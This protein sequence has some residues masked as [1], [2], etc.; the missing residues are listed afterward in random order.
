[1]ANPPIP[2]RLEINGLDDASFNQLYQSIS[3]FNPEAH[4]AEKKLDKLSDQAMGLEDKASNFRNSSLYK[5]A[6]AVE[7]ADPGHLITRSVGAVSKF[8]EN[9]AVIMK[10]LDA[11][12]QV[13]PFISILVLAFQAAIQLE[14][15]RRE[16]DK[17]VLL[18]KTDMM[19][20]MG[21]LLD[22]GSIKDAQKLD[23][24]GTT[25]EGR[26]QR[27]IKNA[28]QDIR[29]CSATCEKYLEKKFFVKLFDGSRWEGRLAAFS[30]VFSR[31]KDELSVALSIHTAQGVDNV[32]RTLVG[33]EANVKTG[34]ESAAM[35]ILF[36]QL[37]SP[38][39]RELQKWILDRGGPKTALIQLFKE[40]QDKMKDSKD[41]SVMSGS[42]TRTLMVSIREEMRENI[43]KSLAADRRQFDR[44][45][46]A[47]Q[48]KLEEMKNTVRRSTDRILIELASGPHDRIRDIDLYTVW[49]D[50]AWKGSVKARHFIVAVQDYFLHKYNREDQK[51]DDAVRG[52]AE[53][54]SGPS[55]PVLS[56]A[57]A[58]T[59]EPPPS[60]LVA[61]AIEARTAQREL[62]D[63]W[64]I[65]YI[66]L[67]RV[68]PILEA[69]DDDGSGWIS[70]LEANTFTSSRPVDY[71]VVKWLAFWAAG[72]RILCASYAQDIQNV[73]SRMIAIAVDVLPPN[74]AR[75]DKYMVSSSFD[76]VD[77]IVRAVLSDWNEDTDNDDA[78]MARFTDYIQSEEK[79]LT[80]GL[81]RFAWE[82][83]APNTLQL[84]AGTGR[85]ERSI[86][87][88]IFLVLKRHT[89]V[90]QLACKQPLDDREL[91]DAER[92]VDVL[93][94]AI[95]LRIFTLESNFRSQRLDPAS[96]FEVAYN[97]MFKMAYAYYNDSNGEIY[98]SEYPESYYNDDSEKEPDEKILKYGTSEA[99]VPDV[100]YRDFSLDD[101]APTHPFNGLW[102]GTYTYG[103]DTSIKDGIVSAHLQ[104]LNDDTQ[105]VFSGS[106]R[107][108]FGSFQISGSIT[109]APEGSSDK[110]GIT[111]RLEY[112]PV[113]GRE[114]LVWAYHGTVS[115]EESG[116]MT[117]MTGEW[118]VWVDD[119][120]KFEAAGTFQ[121]DRT[122]A[123]VAYH[124]PP[125]ADFEANAARARWKL[126]LNV[127]EEQVRR[128]RWSWSYFRQRREDR[129]IFV[130]A[131]V[132]TLSAASFTRY[133]RVWPSGDEENYWE[134]LNSLQCRLRP[135]DT[136][137]YNWLA[138]LR[139]E[140]ECFHPHT[141]C[142]SCGDQIVGVRYRC[143]DCI[144]P[145]NSG[146]GVDLDEKCK[147][148]HVSIPA[149]NIEHSPTAHALL[150]TLRV[151]YIRR[152][153]V[154]LRWAR[155][156]RENA[157]EILDRAE[158]YLARR[159]ARKL[160]DETSRGKAG[161]EEGDENED[162]DDG[163]LI[164]SCMYCNKSV[165]RPCWFCVEC[166]EDIF[167]CDECE[168][169]QAEMSRKV[170]QHSMHD[171]EG[172]E[173]SHQVRLI[174]LRNLAFVNVC[175]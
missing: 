54:L 115:V 15:T 4:G 124:R 41:V 134:T 76:V 136:L 2:P 103:F 32:Q 73:R 127:I 96:E 16:N 92:S 145:G 98:N 165:S 139:L 166:S 147:E 25:V 75:V 91:W 111:F 52:A 148:N 90:L 31:R 38:K 131:T 137:F 173:S 46:D 112:E 104:F 86:L 114:D 3:G 59:D 63:R 168:H 164:P 89:Q 71:S 110:R 23:P 113:K 174:S 99:G 120:S 28:E 154:I 133:L 49:K 118:G 80:N 11:V 144:I 51:M 55:S 153:A 93:T 160:T 108:S 10:G 77:L 83:D 13:H 70:V 62:Q 7:D 82:I 172:E 170:P 140:Q 116:R 146:N 20:M 67:T 167:I 37:E 56:T 101:E 6:I 34:S 40:L 19:N 48:D 69:F 27:I 50:M 175:L 128:R 57:S 94:C 135:E 72:F 9:S 65:N 105:N 64:A 14:L 88:L 95:R 117:A 100:M 39:E 68:R 152:R 12:K 35:L 107:D 44:K 125:A 159:Q 142:D 143:L 81:E 150:R 163:V 121:M 157:T 22:L 24:D 21:I 156:Q 18:L 5:D 123:I 58:T 106:G 151:I 30:D 162:K 84:I 47:V 97:G 130:E 36:K 119:P 8:A 78:L 1:M 132:R 45:F 60:A 161:V 85:V 155:E 138:R 169:T 26:M 17:K 158:A 122:P 129:K 79:R 33:I 109:V 102:T 42:A 74:R 53:G 141:F 61:R 149:K 66:T 43:D 87:P 29:D 171:T 126:A